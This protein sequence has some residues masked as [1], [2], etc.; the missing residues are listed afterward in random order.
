MGIVRVIWCH[1]TQK[2]NRLSD[3]MGG[4]QPRQQEMYAFRLH[5]QLFSST[6]PQTS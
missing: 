5:F 3:G 6:P 1:N 4:V 2:Q